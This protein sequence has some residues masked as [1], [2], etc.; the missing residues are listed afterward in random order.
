MPQDLRPGAD[1]EGAPPTYHGPANCDL[2]AFMAGMDGAELPMDG[3][4]AQNRAQYEAGREYRT[5]VADALGR[6]FDRTVL[7]G[8]KADQ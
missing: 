7:H 2:C 1:P 5:N 3:W 8:L 4:P 6:S